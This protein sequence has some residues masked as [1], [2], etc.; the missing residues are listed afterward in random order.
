VKEREKKEEEDRGGK[1]REE[2]KSESCPVSEFF[3][4]ISLRPFSNLLRWA[5]PIGV[6][7]LLF[8]YQ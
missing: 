2:E 6:T 3:P 8:K 5:F 4:I 1:E 7:E